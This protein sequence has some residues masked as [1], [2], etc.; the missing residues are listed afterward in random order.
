MT[1]TFYPISSIIIV[2]KGGYSVEKFE[3][4]FPPKKVLV[5]INKNRIKAKI[6]GGEK[7]IIPPEYKYIRHLILNRE[8]VFELRGDDENGYDDYDDFVR[9][10]RD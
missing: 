1:K 2:K 3:I 4:G 10:F 7:I 8:L 9:F 6:E 5:D